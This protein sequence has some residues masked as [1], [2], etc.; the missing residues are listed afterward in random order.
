MKAR[1]K[2]PKINKPQNRLQLA[3]VLIAVL[4]IVSGYFLIFHRQDKPME[5]TLSS[6]FA[7]TCAGLD[8]LRQNIYSCYK[9][10]LTAIVN[11]AGPEKATLLLKSSYAQG[12]YAKSECHQLMHVVGAGGLCPLWQLGRSFRPRRPVLL[13]WLLPRHNGTDFR[14][15]RL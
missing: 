1:V 14:P 11:T 7:D 4:A 6:N 5:R 10:K 15:K 3:I 12:G 2:I 8:P 13:V 9:K